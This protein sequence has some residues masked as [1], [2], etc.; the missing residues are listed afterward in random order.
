MYKISVLIRCLNEERF[1]Q[2]IIN[3]IRAQTGVDCRIM[4]LDSGS[5]DSTRDIILRN[6]CE[7]FEIPP[8]DFNFGASC[9]FLMEKASDEH[10]FFVSA[11]AS[12]PQK[13]SLCK[14]VQI[15]D[16]NKNSGAV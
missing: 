6:G 12:L 15:L 8:E 2:R 9:D 16:N 4:F 5:K 10:C 11:H 7:L 14:A 1:I 13:D 3:D